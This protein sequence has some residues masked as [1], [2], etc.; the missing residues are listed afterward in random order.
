MGDPGSFAVHGGDD[1]AVLT[2][3][4]LDDLVCRGVIHRE[5]VRVDGLGREVLPFR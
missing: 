1:L 4:Q 5:A 3:H 2:K